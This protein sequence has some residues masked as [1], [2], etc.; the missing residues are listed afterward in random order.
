MLELDP[1]LDDD[2]QRA[3]FFH[4]AL[5]AILFLP[6]IRCVRLRFERVD[7]TLDCFEVKDTPDCDGTSRSW[8]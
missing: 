5:R 8:R 2:L 7:L 1:R 3:D 4:D 6:K